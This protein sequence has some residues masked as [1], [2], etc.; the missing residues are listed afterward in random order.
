ML[1][2]VT[3]I[4]RKPSSGGTYK[5]V[6]NKFT[7]Y[8]F[9]QQH[10]KQSQTNGNKPPSNQPP[11]QPETKSKQ[12]T[13]NWDWQAIISPTSGPAPGL[14]HPKSSQW[15]AHPGT[16]TQQGIPSPDGPLH[17]RSTRGHLAPEIYV[18]IFF[19]CVKETKI[20]ASI[21]ETREARK[22]TMPSSWTA[23]QTGAQHLS[24][25]AASFVLANNVNWSQQEAEI[26]PQKAATWFMEPNS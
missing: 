1:V 5:Q 17:G 23:S 11:H 15:Q 2:E 18:S 7:P 3:K 24:F 4:C 10:P 26:S 12:C 25:L 19:Y 9:F 16:V 13:N 6:N 22:N 20:C 14:H 8:F 21:W